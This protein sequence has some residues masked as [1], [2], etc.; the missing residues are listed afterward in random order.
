MQFKFENKERI[1]MYI[2]ADSLNGVLISSTPYG[3]P[4]RNTYY[5]DRDNYSSDNRGYGDS[6]RNMGGTSLSSEYRKVPKFFN[7]KNFA[8]IHLK[9]KQRG[10]S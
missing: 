7:K 1:I 8:V 2:N 3:R 4:A 5:K 6:N 10:Q 9:F